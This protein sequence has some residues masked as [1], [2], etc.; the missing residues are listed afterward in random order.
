MV[1]IKLKK[2][3]MK[4]LNYFDMETNLSLHIK[5]FNDKVRVLNQTGS[6]QLILS[7]QEAKSLH[8][9]I[10]DLLNFCSQQS[11][12]L[13]NLQ[14]QEQVIQVSVDGGKFK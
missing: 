5:K 12:Q 11:K 7:A 8:A 10:M 2:K 1:L 9:E 6:K 14:N 3:W 4:H 13:Y